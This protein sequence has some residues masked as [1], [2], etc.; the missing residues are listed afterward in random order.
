[1]CSTTL[2]Y[3]RPRPRPGYRVSLAILGAILLVSVALWVQSYLQAYLWGLGYG[4]R[5]ASL[6]ST[7]G[8]ITLRWERYRRWYPLECSSV[9][10][11]S[12]YGNYDPGF[13]IRNC[14]FRYG[15]YTYGS[16][17]GRYFSFPHLLPVILASAAMVY[18]YRKGVGST[19]ETRV[20]KTMI[21]AGQGEPRVGPTPDRGKA[22]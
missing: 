12:N 5:S 7:Y 21:P 22:Q 9:Q 8:A 11:D 14:G 10:V 18:F 16:I 6:A 1:M 20:R 15:T 17:E 2:E 3:S 13:S 4:Y 19:R